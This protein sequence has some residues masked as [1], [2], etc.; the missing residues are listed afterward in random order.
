M[1]PDDDRV[2]VGATVA[3]RDGIGTVLRHIEPFYVVWLTE[4]GY[5]MPYRHVWPVE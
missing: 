1:T 5:A 2:P 3:T 4:Q